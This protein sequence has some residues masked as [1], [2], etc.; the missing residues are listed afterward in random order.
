MTIGSRLKQRRLSLGYTLD[1]IKQLLS[2]NGVQIS[3]AALSKYELDKSVPKATTL[4]YL[5]Q[6]LNVSSEYFLK[7]INFEINWIAFRKT[8][9]L[10]KKEEERIKFIAKE[11]VEAQLFLN[12][13]I[14]ED[15]E[16][17]LPRYEINSLEE[18]EKVAE[19]LR[20]KWKI[21]NWAIESL[22]SILEEKSIFIVDVDSN[23]GFDGLS[24]M[25]DGKKPIII[26]V[27]E[28]TID[29]KRLNIAHELGHLVLKTNK[30]NE[31]KAA[32]RFAGA[33]L[34]NKEN[35]FNS[36]GKKRRNIDIRELLILKEEYGISIQALIRR[37]FD[38]E[39]I[40]ESEYKRL[41]I[42]MRSTGLHLK[43]PGNCKNKEVP[44]KVKS[45]LFRAISEGLT[46][47]SEV[48]SRFPNLS[49][50]INGVIMIS[51]W[52]NKSEE[53]KIKKLEESAVSLLDEYEEGGSLADFE[54]YDDIQD[55]K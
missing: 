3:K 34:I 13:L 29:R 17:T 31:E 22:T 24:G 10:N 35:L 5:S 20:I 27:G 48:L 37:C 9:K 6:V 53:Y 16:Y 2:N 26:S 55:I 15:I 42:Y 7:K 28:N 44:T 33:F 52:N 4:F 45:R 40:N 8:T 51:D 54:I 36:I 11:Q 30:I 49:S 1:D 39:I 32:F 50:E 41:N 14:K 25:I 18:I 46:T 12:D 38:L 19:D 23:T 43:E 47:E 21:F